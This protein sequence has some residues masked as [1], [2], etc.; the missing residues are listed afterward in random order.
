MATSEAQSTAAVAAPTERSW[1]PFAG[2]IALAI[3]NRGLTFKKSI[4]RTLMKRKTLFATLAAIA[5]ATTLL[6]T[7]PSALAQQCSLAGAAGAYG[8]TGTGTLLLA[9][10]AVP[11]AAAG[12]LNLRVD[13]TLSGTEARSVGGDFANET[14]TGTWTVNA[15]C[16]ATVTAKVFVSGALVR[17][18][19]LSGVFDDN[20]REGRDV[21]KSLTLP[22]GTNVPVVI[23]FEARR[24][25]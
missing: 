16:R 8:F 12:R 23:T 2:A 20:M 3:N 25:F 14:L 6:G 13:G 7:V 19:V 21:Q 1:L 5:L 9:T 11:I 15:N 18:S 4:R 22:D 10:G 17:T 24:I